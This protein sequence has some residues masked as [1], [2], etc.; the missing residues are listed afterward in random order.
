MTRTVTI[1]FE[2]KRR[3]LKVEDEFTELAPEEQ[4]ELLESYIYRKD[5]QSGLGPVADVLEDAARQSLRPFGRMGEISEEQRRSGW[6]NLEKGI[7]SLSEGELLSGGF[8][9]LMGA[10][11]WLLSPVTAITSGAAGEPTRDLAE[12]GLDKYIEAMG[13]EPGATQRGREAGYYTPADALGHTAAAALDVFTPGSY[14]KAV[15]ASMPAGKSVEGAMGYLAGN[16][17]RVPQTTAPYKMPDPADYIPGPP[18]PTVADEAVDEYD[19]WTRL[20]APKT[21]VGE[22]VPAGPGT[23]EHLSTDVVGDIATDA[24]LLT[25]VQRVRELAGDDSEELYRTVGSELG[26]ALENGDIGASSLVKIL[27]DLKIPAKEFFETTI[28]DSARNLNIMSQTAKQL[29]K[30]KD[31]PSTV[32]AELKLIAD[33]IDSTGEISNVEKFFNTWRKVENV[34]RGFMVSQ[35]ATAVRN[36]ISQTGRLSIGM[37]DDMIQGALRGGTARESMKNVWDSVSSDFRALPFIRDKKLLNDVFEGNPITEE[38]LFTRAV[39]ESKAVGKVTK[40][41][42]AM[43]ILQE[44]FFRRVAFQARLDKRLKEVGMDVRTMDPK[45]IPPEI[46]DDAVAHALDISFASNGGKIAQAVTRAFEAVPI[47]YHVNPFPRFAY[48]NALPFLAEHSPYGLFKAFSPKTIAKLSSGNPRDF[49]KFASRGLIGTILLGKA[50]EIRNGPNGG[51]KWYEY[52]VGETDELGRQKT[53]DLRAYAPLSTYLF[54]A[55]ALK[56]DNNLLW[57]DWSEAALGLNRLSGTGLVLIDA[58][59]ARGDDVSVDILMKYVGELTG[60][61]TIPV[62]QFKDF[63]EA[64]TGD[65][66]RRSTRVDD[67]GESFIAPTAA[68]IPWV[69]EEFLPMARS[70]LREGPIR[71]EPVT[72]F[73]IEIPAPAAKQLLGVSIKRKNQVEREVDRLG[74]DPSAYLPRTGVEE[75]NRYIA[76]QMAPMVAN[77]VGRMMSTNTPPAKMFPGLRKGEWLVGFDPD[78][79]YKDLNDEGK[80]LALSAV[81]SIIKQAARKKMERLEKGLYAKVVREGVPETEMRYYESKM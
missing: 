76:A 24:G 21:K 37:V 77:L 12:R 23:V 9:T 64:Y 70:P 48:A 41:V 62:R 57:T 56:P 34:R 22:S 33:Q 81:L 55:E 46:L 3:K 44:K 10:A 60:T 14:A 61:P 79:P 8:N 29:A 66:A 26:A 11:Q 1:N 20:L 71:G 72:L 19:L 78:T 67:R 42:N 39:H 58:V 74:L 7:K 54:L 75:A 4:V 47:W 5:S 53:I 50:M 18:K 17:A 80:V 15:Q 69:S 27:D 36:A 43:N 59:K 51:E 65:D 2:G 52:N 40:A 68:N 13:G 63:Y 32:R 25:R 38:T 30:N 6:K 16:R 28:R 31:L 73:G 45:K 49:A 35:L